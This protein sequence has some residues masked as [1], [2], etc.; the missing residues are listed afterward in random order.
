M[1]HTSHIPILV[2]TSS[3]YKE[4]GKELV[5]T[6]TRRLQSFWSSSG[7]NVCDTHGQSSI[8]KVS[9][10]SSCVLQWCRCGLLHVLQS[11][12]W[13]YFHQVCRRFHTCSASLQKLSCFVESAKCIQLQNL[14]RGK[15][16]WSDGLWH[17]SHCRVSLHWELIGATL[18]DGACES[19]V[20]HI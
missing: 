14:N 1:T 5:E 20:L 12:I 9:I 6:K 7:Q 18:A 3:E 10:S 15:L 8:E 16:F 2:R 13:N 4:T 17:G 19:P 11:F